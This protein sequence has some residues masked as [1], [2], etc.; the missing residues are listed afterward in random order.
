MPTTPSDAKGLLIASVNGNTPTIILEHRWLFGLKGLVNSERY[1]AEIGK[2]EVLKEGKAL[3]IISVSYA[4]IESLEAA[5][6]LEKHD[7]NVEVLDVK[8]I[9][10]IDVDTILKSVEKT[11]RVLIIDNAHIKFGISAEILSLIIENSKFE[12]LSKPIRI[13]LPHAPTPTAYTLS[14]AYYPG[15]KDIIKAV[16]E[17]LKLEITNLSEIGIDKLTDIPNENF[18]GPY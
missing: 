9:S 12:L 6:I 14:E 2:A 13:G 3:T 15:I 1:N 4:S 11:R 5:K 17:I 8:T 18:T 7:I 16:G 10:P